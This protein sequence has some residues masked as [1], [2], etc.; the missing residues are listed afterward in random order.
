MTPTICTAR[1]GEYD[2]RW[3][4]IRQNKTHTD[5]RA[6]WTKWW[7]RQCNIKLFHSVVEGALQRA[8]ADPLEVIRDNELSEFPS[9]YRSYC[10]PAGPEIALTVFGP[11]A[12]TPKG[13]VKI[14]FIR[15]V[16][17]LGTREW[18]RLRRS[19]NTKC[20]QKAAKAEAIKN[21]IRGE[22]SPC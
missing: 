6:L 5:G 21:A 22:F 7:G 14:Q 3:K 17:S 19:Y 11:T 4:F 9:D 20:K 2:A 10:V 15:E 13:Q 18:D 8:A 1:A 16:T 12:L